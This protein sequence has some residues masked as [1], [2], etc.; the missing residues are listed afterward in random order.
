MVS[1]TERTIN[2]NAPTVKIQ[3]STLEIRIW[4]IRRYLA[5][6]LNI[7]ARAIKPEAVSIEIILQAL[8]PQILRTYLASEYAQ[9]T[10]SETIK[11]VRKGVS[12]LTKIMAKAGYISFAV[13]AEI[14]SIKVLPNESEP[15]SP[16]DPSG[17]TEDQ[18]G[19]ISFTPTTT[20]L[21]RETCRGYRKIIKRYLCFI[22]HLQP[23]AINCDA[24]SIRLLVN[25][26]HTEQ[27]KAWLAHIKRR[28]VS[29]SAVSMACKSVIALAKYLSYLGLLLIQTKRTKDSRTADENRPG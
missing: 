17:G 21:T 3:Q 18:C 24:L 25:S 19:V 14:S 23:G 7:D 20:G 2:L 29:K 13:A 12:Y 10:K 6:T 27:F 22:H 1:N 5:A 28:D 4:S 11:A 8:R 15:P 26:L 16:M 9:G